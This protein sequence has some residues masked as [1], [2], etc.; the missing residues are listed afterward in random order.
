[1]SVA[2]GAPESQ[3]QFFLSHDYGDIIAQELLYRFKQH[4]SGLFTIKSLC[5]SDGGIFP[6]THCLLLQKILKDESKQS[7]ILT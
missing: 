2:S 6:E 3:N 7:P 5:L 4:L 1:M